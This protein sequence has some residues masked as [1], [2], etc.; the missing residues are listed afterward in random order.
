MA[1]TGALALPVS[2][3]GLLWEL[4]LLVQVRAYASGTGT[5]T[6]YTHGRL[7]LQTATPSGTTGN[8][9]CWPMPATSGPTA[10]TLDVSVT[11]TLA[12]VGT[13]S[14][15][16]GSPSITCTNFLVEPLAT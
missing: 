2:V 3:T 14:Q 4:E 6:V 13:L 1:T 12:L 7:W 5:N 10:A 8:M 15:A 11:H 16:T 9:Q